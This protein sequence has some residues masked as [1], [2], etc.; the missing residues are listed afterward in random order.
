MDTRLVS[1]SQRC[2][3]LDPAHF[4]RQAQGLERFYWQHNDEIYAGFGIAAEL[5]AW[6][7]DHFQSIRTKAADL[8]RDVMLLNKDQSAARPRLFGPSA[9]TTPT[10]A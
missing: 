9:S 10:D 3:N 4:L 1:Y 6:G 2:P 5:T 8:F 7:E